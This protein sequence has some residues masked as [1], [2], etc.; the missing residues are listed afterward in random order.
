[1]ALETT[2]RTRSA[3]D[4]RGDVEWL[5]QQ[6]DRRAG[7][8]LLE[9]DVDLGHALDPAV[10]DRLLPMLRVRVETVDEGPWRPE[11]VADPS[12][13]GLIL[14]DGLLLRDLSLHERWC[15]ELLGP[16]DLMR[17]WLDPD[18]MAGYDTGDLRWQVVDG[19]VRVAVIDRPASTLMGR[20][21][22]IVNE[23][24]DRSLARAR[25]LQ[26]QLA[27]TQVHGIGR[28]LELL[29]W[30]LAD[31]WGRVTPQGVVVPLDL[32]HEMLGR[33]IGARRPSVTT[34]LRALADEGRVERTR[35]GW[36][37]ARD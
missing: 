3:A 30:H 24:L 10:R 7:V 23:L 29:L 21:P 31:R 28:R 25:S 13:F 4:G 19:P 35:D 12:G 11:D 22:A 9:A 33:L 34:A 18:G 27:L 8:R 14:L 26:F 16:G 1:M 2:V 17:P 5:P 15:A 6:D 36:V 37:L 20:F 32:T